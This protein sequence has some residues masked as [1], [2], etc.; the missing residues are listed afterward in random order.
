MYQREKWSSERTK[1]DVR[2]ILNNSSIIICI[3]DQQTNK[4]AA[5]SRIL[6]D[7][8]KFA[9]VYDVIVENQYRGKGIGDLL[10]ASIMEHPK[11][12]NIENIELVCTKEMIPFYK[13]FGFSDDYGASVSMRRKK[14][15]FNS[16]ITVLS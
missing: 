14:P 4:L 5:F 8:F 3:I 16:K 6:T 11:L 1:E 15:Q 2:V 13:K 9:Y 10:I 12:M 7:Y